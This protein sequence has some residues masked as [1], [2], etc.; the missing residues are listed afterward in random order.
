MLPLRDPALLD[1]RRLS[2]RLL[3]Y[4]ATLLGCPFYVWPSCQ[5]IPPMKPVGPRL[6]FSVSRLCTLV[7]EATA[8]ICTT[9]PQTPPVV[10]CN[11]R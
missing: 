6:G 7:F 3:S 1:N 11:D 2:S 9:T 10:S 4:Q 5:P 8:L